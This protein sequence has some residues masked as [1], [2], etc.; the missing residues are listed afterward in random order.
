[1][2]RR[3]LL[4]QRGGAFV[5]L[6]L[7]ITL[8]ITI[9]WGVM[10]FAHAVFAYNNVAFLAREGSRWAAVRGA[11]SGRTATALS[12]SEYTKTRSTGLDKT[13][14][15]VNATWSDASKAPGSAVTVSV[16]YSGNPLPLNILKAP[17]TV[18][19]NSTATILQ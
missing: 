5:E 2:K 18:R 8:F 19:S 3:R 6:A 9:L 7:C 4:K 1:M 17:L 14:L 13:K 16:S 11:N 12:V 15:T 10:S